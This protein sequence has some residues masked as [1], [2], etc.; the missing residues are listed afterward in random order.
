MRQPGSIGVL[1]NLQKRVTRCAVDLADV[2]E[3]LLEE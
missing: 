1:W 2:V 3:E